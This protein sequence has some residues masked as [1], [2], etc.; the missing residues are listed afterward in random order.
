MTHYQGRCHCGAV[1]F[2]FEGE[3]ID[4]GVRCNCSM[5]ARRGA[6]MS[7]YPIPRAQFQIVAEPQALGLYQFG[8]KTAEHYFCKRCGIYPFH[9]PGRYPDHYR[10]NLACIDEIDTFALPFDVLDGRQL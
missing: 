7:P 3:E 1:R 8:E 10:V 5:C 9:V 4:R 6:M 2:S